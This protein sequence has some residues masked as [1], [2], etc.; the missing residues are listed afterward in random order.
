MRYQRWLIGLFT[1]VLVG[2]TN[3]LQIGITPTVIPFPTVT[4]EPSV[5]PFP[6]ATPEP[7][8]KPLSLVT[9]SPFVPTEVV[10][11]TATQVVPTEVALATQIV[12]TPELPTTP[13][14]PLAECQ[15]AV[16]AK[17]TDYVLIEF[18]PELMRL[19]PLSENSWELVST[20]TARFNNPSVNATFELLWSCKVSLDAAQQWSIDDVYYT[21]EW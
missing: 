16:Q 3:P 4:P 13:E 20:V 7:S 6:T 11:A 1:I 9:A 8:V 12:P 15:Q 14:L 21:S 10:L 5:I 18:S 2:C 17:A 19:T